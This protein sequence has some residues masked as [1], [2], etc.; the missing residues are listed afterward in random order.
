MR[1]GIVSPA[2]HVQPAPHVAGLGRSATRSR[3]SKSRK[4]P[5]G[6]S[7]QLLSGIRAFRDEGGLS[8]L[9]HLG[10][11]RRSSLHGPPCR[12]RFESGTASFPGGL[13]D[14]RELN[15]CHPTA[16]TQSPNKPPEAT[17]HLSGLAGIRVLIVFPYWFQGLRFLGAPQLWMFDL[18][19]VTGTAASDSDENAGRSGTPRRHHPHRSRRL[20][21]TTRQTHRHHRQQ[22]GFHWC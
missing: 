2:I 17:L 8:R 13:A 21:R 16:P 11:M 9:P 1:G 22:K 3:R 4:I 14:I 12:H 18:L 20:R 5:V 10:R 15:P 7:P 19:K 6:K